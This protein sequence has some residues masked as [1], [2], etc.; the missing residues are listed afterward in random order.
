MHKYNKP[1]ENIG[2]FGVSSLVWSTGALVL[3]SYGLY[4]AIRRPK[5]PTQA[6]DDEMAAVLLACFSSL[7]TISASYRPNTNMPEE[8][9]V[10]AILSVPPAVL[11]SAMLR[12]SRTF[13]IACSTSAT[14]AAATSLAIALKKYP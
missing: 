12:D 6:G 10:N 9:L 2:A 14:V 5:T 13:E 3:S 8:P 7:Y 1:R 4:R 11:F